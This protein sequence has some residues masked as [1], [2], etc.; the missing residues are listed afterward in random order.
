MFQVTG[1]VRHRRL[2]YLQIQP[3]SVKD[4]TDVQETAWEYQYVFGIFRRRRTARKRGGNR[5]REAG[6]ADS[7]A[8]RGEEA[9]ALTAGLA[10]GAAAGGLA[11]GAGKYSGPLK[12]QAAKNRVRLAQASKV[13]IRMSSNV[14]KSRY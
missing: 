12:P 11:A 6:E 1:E 3:L 14:A 4:M 7:A 2:L 8:A 13:R 9:S 5:Q 10:A